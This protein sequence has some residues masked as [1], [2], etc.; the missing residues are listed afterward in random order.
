MLHFLKW[1]YSSYQIQTQGQVLCVFSV[2]TR[3]SIRQ[4]HLPVNTNSRWWH[5]LRY[6]PMKPLLSDATFK[7]N[8][9]IS[10][11]YDQ[12]YRLT[13]QTALGRRCN[14]SLASHRHSRPIEGTVFTLLAD[15]IKHLLPRKNPTFNWNKMPECWHYI[16]EQYFLV[17]DYVSIN[18]RGKDINPFF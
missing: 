5:G 8:F 15:M 7:G 17:I 18:L 9:R 1:P 2:T 3:A 12:Q 6:W 13:A 10:C 14:L 4:K 16:N 11:S